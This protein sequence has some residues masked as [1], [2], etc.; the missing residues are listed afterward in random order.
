MARALLAILVGLSI[1]VPAFAQ[2]KPPAGD[3]EAPVPPP[4]GGKEVDLPEDNSV[5]DPSG[6]EENPDSPRAGTTT[7][8]EVGGTVT[9]PS[10]DPD[11]VTK[12]SF[13]IEEVARPITLP[14]L[15]SEAGLDVRNNIDP[16]DGNTT[17]RGRF[18]ITRQIQIG[19]EYN[20]GGFYDDGSG[21]GV[22]FNT[23]KSI[24]LDVQYLIQDWVA[25][26]L[27]LPFYLDP[28]S[29]GM[30]LG[31]PMKFRILP[32]LAI[33]GFHDLLSITF[34]N[35][36]PSTTDE[37]YNELNAMLV[38]SG[39]GLPDGNIRI[40]AWAWYQMKPNLALGGEMGLTFEDFK[41]SDVPY[42]L[43]GR[44]QYSTSK[45]LDFGGAFGFGDLADASNT[46]QLN[47]YAQLRI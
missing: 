23:G 20:I 35:F 9:A 22:R 47:L 28:F 46:I 8:V 16:Y 26:R 15:M 40:S 45:K 2:P 43:R 10:P 39:T 21:D 12:R 7:G 5:S 36:V 18:G 41:D 30:T 4:E 38:D 11:V 6:M 42:S 32:K 3:D 13:P 29:M 24:G 31:A 25:V 34:K 33:G 27:A 17:L 1:S 19:L 14:A 44:I 37:A